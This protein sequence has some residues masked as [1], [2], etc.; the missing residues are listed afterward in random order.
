TALARQAREPGRSLREPAGQVAQVAAAGA[1]AR[2]RGRERKLERRDATP[3][4]K[5]VAGLE[6]F[7]SRRRRGGVARRQV[8]GAVTEGAPQ[9]LTVLPLADRRGALVGGGPVGDLL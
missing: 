4:P 7:Q 8:D 5:E 6:A 3:R 9:P 2:P 1:R